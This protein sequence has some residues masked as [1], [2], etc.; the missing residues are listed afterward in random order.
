MKLLLKIQQFLKMKNNKQN[1][2]PNNIN[3][4]FMANQK[5]FS[6]IL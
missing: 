2:N 4:S 3:G 5:K 6:E 1:E